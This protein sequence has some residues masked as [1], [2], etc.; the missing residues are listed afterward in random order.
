MAF[1]FSQD[2]GRLCENLIFI[3]LRRRGKKVYYW[4]G[5]GEVDFVVMEGMKV[6]QLIQSWDI[7]DAKTKE[8]EMAGLAEAMG[9]LEVEEGIVVT[10]DYFGEEEIEGKK[11]RF[12]PLWCWLLRK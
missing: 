4:K 7:N 6:E 3:D 8:R 2:I 11:I 1:R 9:K 12:I 5:K 10:D